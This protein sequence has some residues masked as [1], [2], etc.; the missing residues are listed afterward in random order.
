MEEISLDPSTPERTISIGT[1]LPVPLKGEMVNLLKK[2]QDIFACTAEQVVGVLDQLMLHAV[3]LY[4]RVKPVK[5]KRRHFGPECNKAGTEEVDK[6][7]PTRM[8]KEVQ[9]PT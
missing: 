5:Q 7:L 9:Y 4:P 8:I 6:L 2:Y 3:T 1:S